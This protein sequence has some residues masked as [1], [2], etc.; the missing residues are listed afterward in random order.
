MSSSDDSNGYRLCVRSHE[1]VVTVDGCEVPL[2]P[3]EYAIIRTLYSRPGWV[4][5]ALQLAGDADDSDYAPESVSVLVS[6]LRGKLARAGAPDAIDTVRGFGYRLK[7]SGR[8]CRHRGG[9]PGRS[10]RT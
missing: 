10:R 8:A 9:S 7:A 3:R 6:R 2:T 4:F 5:S 1:H